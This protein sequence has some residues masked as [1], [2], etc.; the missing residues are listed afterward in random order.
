MCGIGGCVVPAGERPDAERLEAIRAALAHRGPDDS[1]TEIVSNAG[2]VHTR[3]AIVD[4]STRGAQPMRD[5]D[6]RW[7]L[8]YNGEVFNHRELRAE[9]DDR[10]FSGGSDTE[11]V[12]F[13]LA[14][15]GTDAVRRFNG[16]FAFAAL[17]LDRNR[18]LLVRDR[19]GVKPLYLARAGGALWFASEI[20]ALLAAGVPARPARET[21]AYSVDFRFPSE[22]QTLIE[23]IERLPAGSLMSI[24]LETLEQRVR[25]WYDPAKE[26]D[27]ELQAELQRLSRVEL[28][29]RVEE[30]LQASVHRRLMAD[31]PIG[32]MCSGGLDSSLVTAFA[33]ERRPDIVAFSVSV[34]SDRWQNEGPEASRAATALGVDLATAEVT[35]TSW[36]DSFVEAVRHFEHPFTNA[37]PI[38]I[39]HAARLARAHG[40]KA[41]LT[42]EGADELMGGYRILHRRGMDAFLPRRHRILQMIDS[43]RVLGPGGS[44]AMLVRRALRHPEGPQPLLTRNG[45]PRAL[46]EN[47]ERAR[48]AYAHHPGLRGSLEAELLTDLSFTLPHLLN[49]MD[50]N[51]MQASIEAR[52][53]FLDPGV[54]RLLVNLPLEARL[55]PRTKGVLRDV[56]RAHL[57]RSVAHRPKFYGM[58]FTPAWITDAADPSFVL[59]GRLREVL[60]VPAPEWGELVSRADAPQVVRMWSAEVWCRTILDGGPVEAVKRELWPSGP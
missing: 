9:L 27:E 4:P 23:G 37:S 49:R 56:G 43:V 41:L 22:P 40:V 30:E 24:E 32:S 15:W 38:G 59:D 5:P 2:L 7:W 17:D 52:T 10:G 35:P 13:S 47:L 51:A 60:E 25:R 16:L 55:G 36:R 57:P 28:A 45:R 33:R 42:G 1:G 8:T 48:A 21:I 18:L 11:T 19:F 54:V 20:G 53:P 46:E 14:R 29:R 3:L 44:A 58:A 34:P 12:L 6:G 26:V 31:V 39:L 50:K